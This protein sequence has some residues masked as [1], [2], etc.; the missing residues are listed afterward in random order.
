[1]LIQESVFDG[2]YN[3]PYHPGCLRS[4]TSVG[5]KITI[6]GRYTCLTHRIS[7]TSIVMIR[8]RRQL[9]QYLQLKKPR[10]RFWWTSVLREGQQTSLVSNLDLY[11]LLIGVG[12]YEG[13]GIHWPDGNTWEKIGK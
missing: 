8:A 5:K 11:A 13:S 1:M 2:K 7:L 12:V 10:G 9:G 6:T 3:D 4:V